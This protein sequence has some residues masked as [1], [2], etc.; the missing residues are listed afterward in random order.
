LPSRVIV[1]SEAASLIRRLKAETGPLVF[2]Q[3][4]GFCKGSAPMCFRDRDFRIGS[5]DVLPGVIK[6][7]PFFAAST[8][9]EYWAYFELTIDVT[10]GGGDSFSIEATDG[11]RFV[12]RSRLFTDAEAALIDAAGPP[13]RGPDAFRMMRS[14]NA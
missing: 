9:F 13:P 11:I 10:R 1:T 8:E 2:H 6:G 14:G 12:T 3:S 7:C 5:R 4:S